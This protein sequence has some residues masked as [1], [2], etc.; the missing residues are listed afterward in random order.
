MNAAL[1]P[2]FLDLKEGAIVVSL[3]PFAKPTK[4]TVLLTERNFDDF[5]AIFE[6]LEHDYHEGTVSWSGG[7]GHFYTHKVNRKGYEE[8]RTKFEAK[9]EAKSLSLSSQ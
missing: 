1:Q 3:K 4:G 6:V 8:S 2:K 5:S 7:S 9:F